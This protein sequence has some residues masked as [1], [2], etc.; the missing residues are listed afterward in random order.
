MSDRFLSQ[1]PSFLS[2]GSRRLENASCC[3]ELNRAFRAEE[4][5]HLQFFLERSDLLADSGPR[6]VKLFRCLG[7]ALMFGDGAK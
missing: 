1:L 5:L 2:E 6:N 4:Q 3:G 7:E